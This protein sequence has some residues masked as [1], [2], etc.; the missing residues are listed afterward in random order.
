MYNL[1]R[2]S[3]ILNILKKDS[4][5]SVNDLAEY[6]KISKE[7]IRRDLRE[8]EINGLI[9][10]THGG[11]IAIPKK[12]ESYEYPLIIRSMYNHEEKLSI[13]M[14][15]AEFICD[16]DT[17]FVDNS[18]TC[19][20]LLKYIDKNIKITVVTN[21]IQLLLE[22][23]KYSNENIN[24]IILGG[25]FRAS[26]FSLYGLLSQ[27]NANTF[28]PNK[29]F[30]SCRG[31]CAD[32]GFTEAGIFEVEVK[33]IFLEHSKELFFL[34]DSSKFGNAGSIHLADISSADYIIT[35]NKI[36]QE[37]VDMVQNHHVKLIIA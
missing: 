27:N 24:T 29:A 8:M 33:R 11:C 10:R 7:T 14:K 4:K 28:Y 13:C 18:S 34:N 32:S 6:F 37:Y 30:F 17:I 26:N 5:V 36:K 35:D 25:V 3:A 19:M 1:E 21:S 22:A 20:N 23:S 16:G 31:I 9:K 12:E 15:A 2:K